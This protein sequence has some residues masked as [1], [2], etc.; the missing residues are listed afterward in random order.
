M[1]SANQKSGVSFWK[2]RAC[3]VQRVTVMRTSLLRDDCFACAAALR[4]ETTED[5]SHTPRPTGRTEDQVRTVVDRVAE[6]GRGGF[7]PL[8]LPKDATRQP[9]PGADSGAVSLGGKVVY[10]SEA[11]E[12]AR[13]R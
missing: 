1:I 13:E 8:R 10:G 9:C 5:A 12:G 11:P 6:M 3:V 4:G 2:V 7:A